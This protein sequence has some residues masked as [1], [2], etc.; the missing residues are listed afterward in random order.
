MVI[1]GA[2]SPKPDPRRRA[3]KPTTVR[4]PAVSVVSETASQ[5]QHG[6]APHQQGA[7]L[8]NFSRLHALV[9]FLRVDNYRESAGEMEFELVCDAWVGGSYFELAHHPQL[10]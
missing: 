10:R 3:T 6:K 4:W 1:S 5:K 9:P 8:P 7:Q 2:L